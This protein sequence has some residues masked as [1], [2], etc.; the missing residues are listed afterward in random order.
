MTNTGPGSARRFEVVAREEAY[1]GFFRLERITLRHSQFR[2]GMSPELVREI[3]ERGDVAAVLLYDPRLDQVVM[4]EQFRVGAMGDANGP[5]LLEIV[6]GL[7]EPGETPEQ[8]ARREALEEAGCTVLDLE[9]VTTFYATPAKSSERS[10]LFCGRV[11]ASRAGGVFGLAHEGE[12]IRVVPLALNE[13]LA[14][15]D[16]GAINSAWPIIA[17]QWLARHRERLRALW[18]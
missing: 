16:N 14:R 7:I 11:D 1:Q 5:W 2:G 8:V 17:L 10:Y 6:A 3:V 9:P 4:I 18:R 12:D 15:V 13:A